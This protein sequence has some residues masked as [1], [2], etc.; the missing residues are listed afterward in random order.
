MLNNVPDG[1]NRM[2]RNVVINHPNTF[3]CRVFR[4]TV[5]RTGA[6]ESTVDGNPTL[7]GLGVLNTADEEQYEYEWIG[8]GYALP[9]ESFMPASMMDRRDANIGPGDEFRFLI[10]SEEPFGRPEWFDVRT[11]DVVYLL[12]G[13]GPSPAMLA[14][15]VVGIETTSNIPPY[16]TRYVTN[17]RDDLHLPA[18]PVGDP[19]DDGG[20]PDEP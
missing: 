4:K 3:N 6:G 17:R 12:L 7:G 13:T 15:E 2:S 14:F 9:A 10:E 19:E 5:T 18:G 11:H 16:T 1:I 8:N 20:A